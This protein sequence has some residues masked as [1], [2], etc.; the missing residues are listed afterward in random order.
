MET[1]N[2]SFPLPSPPLPQTGLETIT[3]SKY[4][5]ET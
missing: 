2:C 4:L 3:G 1:Q 5:K